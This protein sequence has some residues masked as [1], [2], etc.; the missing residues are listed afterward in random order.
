VA[1][2]EELAVGA[3]Y[4]LTVLN[5]APAAAVQLATLILSTDGQSILARYGFAPPALK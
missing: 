2:P 3:D 4:G 1:L 5:G